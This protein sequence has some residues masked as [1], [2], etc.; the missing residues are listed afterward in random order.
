MTLVVMFLF[1]SSKLES[2]S[3]CCVGGKN[4]LW[5]YVSCNEEQSEEV[6][7]S[8]SISEK[9]KKKPRYPY[10]NRYPL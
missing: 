9:K 10:E 5:T 8:H 2:V 6:G 3:G 4:E 1:S 7:E